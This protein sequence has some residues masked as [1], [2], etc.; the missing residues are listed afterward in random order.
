MLGP[1]FGRTD[2]D[3]FSEAEN[4]RLDPSRSDVSPTRGPQNPFKYGNSGL[5]SS[6][7]PKNAKLNHNGSNSH[8]LV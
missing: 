5:V 7:R 1:F 4:G 6:G 2:Q 8:L 3:F